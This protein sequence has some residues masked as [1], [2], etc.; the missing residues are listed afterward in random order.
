VAPRRPARH[1]RGTRFTSAVADSAR[2]EP[3][4]VGWHAHRVPGRTGSAPRIALRLVSGV[5]VLVV[6]A[7]CSQPA[8]EPVAP[9]PRSPLD[10]FTAQRLAWGPCADYADESP[11]R[12]AFRA[13]GI[14]CAR[15]AV[16]LDYADPGGTTAS[17]GVLRHRADGDRIGALVVNPG[18]P[19]ASGMELVPALVGRLPGSPLL[20]RFDLVG[21]DPRGVGSSTPKINCLGDA[22]WAAERAD[23]DVDPS[24]PGVAQ[25]EAENRRYAELCTERS[26]GPAVLA[27]L[28]TREVVRDLDVL[29][30]ALGEQKLSYLGF[31]YGTRLGAAYAEQ[32][33]QRVRALV[34]DGA[35]SPTASTLEQNVAQ[36]AG[37]QHAF[38]AF[39]AD[40]A[41]RGRCPLG[42]D[43][44]AANARF[45]ALVRPLIDRPARA[46]ESRRLSY[47]DAIAAVIQALYVESL[48]PVLTR[49]LAGLAGGDGTVLLTLADL[50]YQRAP[51]GHYGDLIE[52][53]ITISCVDDQRITDRGVATELARRTVAAAPF[54]DSGRGPVGAL[55]PCAFWPVP[56]TRE[57]HLPTAPELPPTVVI[58]T[59]GDPA[60][61][62]AAGVELA[63]ALGAEL[64]T[65]EGNRHTAALQ[66]N[67]C[68]DDLVT[69]YLVELD[70]P[71]PSRC[72]LE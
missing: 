36:A 34:L 3:R 53:F 57:P 26:G 50:Y 68:V 60:T 7:A 69:R 52:A 30:A 32:F 20:H 42:T 72:P 38:D 44:A 16:P 65:V 28:G 4:G 25:T 47:P 14:E 9:T 37:F 64:V 71:G 49:G 43:R 59:T 31:S 6:V 67:A 66:G 21:F 48:W 63:R 18:G 58:S 51:D 15:L 39:A 46:A 35:L 41:R 56:P 33:P 24:P 17:I 2:P 27:H 40:C 45:Q 23:V 5:L 13:A 54:R 70:A 29:R 10:R 8:S 11:E 22:D 62:Y 1:G 61:P 19:G 12:L 55:E